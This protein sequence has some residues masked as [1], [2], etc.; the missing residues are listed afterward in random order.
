[1]CLSWFS[2][3][4]RLQ[5][6][7]RIPINLVLNGS[8]LNIYNI[9]RK[10]CRNRFCIEFCCC[11]CLALGFQKLLFYCGKKALDLLTNFFLLSLLLR[12]ERQRIKICNI[13]QNAHKMWS[14]SSSS[15]LKYFDKE[16]IL[17]VQINDIEER[18]W[19]IWNC[20]RSS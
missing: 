18:L 1:M 20:R 13:L 14:F 3:W 19:Q 16:N 9:C 7:L 8:A 2:I 4:L 12:R 5:H 10:S 11:Y 6:K 17:E 15:S